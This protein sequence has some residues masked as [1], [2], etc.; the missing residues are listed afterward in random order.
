M[1]SAAPKKKDQNKK[2]ERNPDRRNGKAPK[3]HPKQ[4]KRKRSP[5]ELAQIEAERQARRDAHR[6]EVLRQLNAKRIADKA[7]RAAEKIEREAKIK[8]N[9][10]MS[11]AQKR[12][13]LER[14]AARKI[15]AAMRKS[16]ANS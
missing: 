5:E 3:K 4:P 7:R 16:R 6:A 10:R 2:G 11:Q 1:A 14:E 15:T 8:E 13:E 9:K 12:R